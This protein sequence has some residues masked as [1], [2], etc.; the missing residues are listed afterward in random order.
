MARFAITA[1]LAATLAA[2]ANAVPAGGGDALSG[3][4]F[5]GS[6]PSVSSD[7]ARFVFE[8]NDS[9]WIAST[10][11]GVAARLTPEE[12][13]EGWPV[14]SPDSSR[15]A[16]LSTRD[17]G[18]KIFE[19]D[20]ASGEVRQLSRHSE[21][22][23]LSGWMPDGK[24]VIGAA[25]RDD[26][27]SDRC[28]RIAVFSP[29][30]AE[31]F[32]VPGVVTRDAVMSP[33]GRVIA[34]SRRVDDIYRKRRAGPVSQDPEI[35]TYDTGSGQF[36][37]LPTEA[38]CAYFPRWR[39]DGAALYYLGRAKGACVASVREYDFRNRSDREVVSFGDD[40]VFQPSVS[41]DGR[42]MVVR[43][44]FDFWRFDPT[45][46]TPK[47]KRISLRP[48]GYQPRGEGTRRRWYSK[49]S[50]NDGGGDITFTSGG[51]E[52]AFTAG[53]GL[54]AMDTVARSPR[55]VADAPR[56]RVIEC[57]FSPDGSRLYFLVDRGD[58]TDLKV[59]KRTDP[60]LPWWENATFEISTLLSGDAKLRYLT[61][62]P[63]GSRIGFADWRGT[64]TFCDPDGRV[65]GTVGDAVE[66]GAYAWSPDGSHAA[67][68]LMDANA[69]YD[70]WIVRTDGEGEPYNVTRNWKWDGTP[71]WSPDG[72]ILAWA[73]D[74]AEGSGQELRYV[75][76]DPEDEASDRIAEYSRARKAITGAAQDAGAATN[77]AGWKIVYDGLAERVRRTGVSGIS[78]FFSHD[79]R[80]LAY[81]T[82]SATDTICIPG[83]MKPSRLSAKRGRNPVWYA[84]DDRL[85]WVV[86]DKPAHLN[87]VFDFRVYREDGMADWREL[88]FRTAWARIRDRFYDRNCHGVDWNAA[89]TRYL[90]AARAASSYSVFMRVMLMMLGELDASHLG[91][92]ANS[93]AEVEWI[94]APRVHAWTRTTGHLG[95][96]FAPGSTEVAEVVPGSPA[97]GLI[98]PGETVAAIDGRPVFSGAD[99]LEAM[100]IPEGS[101]VLVTVAGREGEPVHLKPAPYS[102]MRSLIEAEETRN[103]RAKVREETGG[104]VGYL[105]V[106][107]MNMESYRKFE[108]E[109]F[110]EGWDKD[111]LVI[112][113]RGNVG[114]FTCDRLL[115]ILC[116]SDHSKS[117]SP[118]GKVGYLFGYWTRP[119]FPKPVAVIIDERTQSNGEIFAH[120]MKTLKRG[121]VIG[122]ATAGAVIATIDRPLLDY[123][124][125]RDAFW[126]WCLPDG[127][128][129]ENHPVV[130]DIEVDLTPVD[131]ADGRD[132]QLDAAIDALKQRLVES[133]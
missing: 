2:C 98:R 57:F 97:D 114:G 11:G 84:K 89:K 90:P 34:F 123:G 64:M 83:R 126:G 128:D 23:Y 20:L 127:T 51:M 92:Y 8:W 36:A 21:S 52:I 7:G 22:T 68:E 76:L 18:R 75:Y 95:I 107:Q 133:P 94:R 79:S 6:C 101:S 73:S 102:K 60:S 3:R 111:A 46:A 25:D 117:I 82:G 10:A 30:G 62:S 35:W 55:L 37:R 42:T 130:P 50:N 99:V 32:P 43:A 54:Y 85:A 121:V 65:T 108:E 72:K 119:V 4:I 81:D 31:A 109:V 38:E 1:A 96:R 86:D 61:V 9:I 41:A 59:A 112:D 93:A 131:E 78:P 28:S 12:T 14:F 104:R 49:S 33:D 26:A 58:G 17:G 45:E 106:R 129:M 124:V 24:S 5:L 80:T 71:A 66:T 15:V 87:T 116:G 113:L 13:R 100:S 70:I 39:P 27:P 122:R 16:F 125:M 63:D 74:K 110:A 69:N 105:A 19:M 77:S 29:G 56:Q 103:V 44:R 67:V 48:G 120:A 47:P 115:S 40:A 118:N 132:P 53:G 88:V 91:F